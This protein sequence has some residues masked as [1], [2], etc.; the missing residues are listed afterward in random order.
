MIKLLPFLLVFIFSFYRLGTKSSSAPQTI[1]GIVVRASD[2]S[3]VAQARVRIQGKN[4]FV[5]TDNAG[6]FVLPTNLNPGTVVTLAAGKYGWYNNA[7]NAF[8]GDVNDTIALTLLPDGDNSDYVFKP[9]EDCNTCHATLVDQW[10]QSKH[11][12]AATNPMLKQIYNGTDVN[13]HTGVYPGFKLNFP[14]E[15][16]DCGD[17][18]APSAALRTP[19]NT[20]LNDVW[21]SQSVDTNGVYCDFCHK[22]DS[23]EVNYKTGVNGSIFVKRPPL[24]ARDIN[25]GPF[26][27]VTSYWMG[28]TYNHTMETSAY[29]SGCHQYANRNGLIVDDTYDSWAVSSYASQGVQCQDCHM[30]PNSDSIFAG[31]IGGPH[32]VAR[33][34]NRIYNQRF[35]GAT[36]NDMLDASAQMSVQTETSF[37]TLQVQNLI[38][39]V[40]AGHKLPTGV[41]FRNMIQ[42]V[43]VLDGIDTLQQISGSAVPSFGGAGNPAQGNLSGLPGKVYAMVTRDNRTGESPSPNWLA[44][45]IVY[46]SRIPAQSTDTAIYKFR[47][48]RH[49]QAQIHVQLIYRA[50]YKPWADAKGWDM[51]EYVMADTSLQVTF[52]ESVREPAN[53]SLLQNYPNPFNGFTRIRYDLQTAQRVTLKI[54]NI[55]GQEIRALVHEQKPAGN[56]FVTWDGKNNSGET[57]SSGLYFYRIRAGA[58]VKTKKLLFVK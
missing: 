14:N 12:H 13:G 31:G 11:S 55:L 1:S 10:K 5:I 29:C 35:R 34:T 44:N 16:G 4:D 9:P 45:E 50:V 19:G 48:G 32:A 22:I 53:F 25:I 7:V 28:G 27:D 20:E 38:T 57:V 41:S 26:D 30:R 2:L 39:N 23:V 21:A 8:V 37:N 54:Y 47:I 17:C 46:D 43:T 58:Y 49:A 42:L 33:D 15:G 18:H 51:R 3:P 24:N 52:D 56:H 6:M 36:S 40:G